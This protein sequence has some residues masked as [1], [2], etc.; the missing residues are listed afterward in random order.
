MRLAL[1]TLL[2]PEIEAGLA[3]YA[4]T[5][6][7]RVVE[8]TGPLAGQ[9]WVVVAPAGGGA[10]LSLAEPKN[11]QE[12]A[13]MG[14]QTGGRVGFFLASDDFARDHARM[15]DLGVSFE[16][17]P[18]HEAYGTVAVW[19]DPFGNR[20]DLVEWRSGA[21]AAHKAGGVDG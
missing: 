2:V 11:E 1:V 15:C 8:D 5:L 12:R 14:A 20:W 21:M 3:F 7:F 19:R 17:A 13:A 9:R 18:R 16:E 4:G 6:G 10:G